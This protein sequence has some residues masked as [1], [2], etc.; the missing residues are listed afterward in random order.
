MCA[1]TPAKAANGEP[2]AGANPPRPSPSRT[3]TSLRSWLLAAGYQVRGH[4]QVDRLPRRDVETAVTVAQQDAERAVA[5]VGRDHVQGPVCADVRD[6][7]V[8]RAGPDKERRARGRGEQDLQ[9]RLGARSSPGDA[10]TRHQTREA[11]ERP[12]ERHGSSLA[13]LRILFHSGDLRAASGVYTPRP[14]RR[15]P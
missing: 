5:G 8:A 15:S 12:V 7:H 3:K 14:F 11:A 1:L 6:H 10:E 4:V 13:P 9:A 2:G